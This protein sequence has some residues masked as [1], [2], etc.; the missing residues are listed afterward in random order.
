MNKTRDK[1]KIWKT[2]QQCRDNEVYRKRER[3]RDTKK[4]EIQKRERKREERRVQEEKTEEEK[5]MSRV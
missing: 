1:E 5:D 4:K 2:D 3:E